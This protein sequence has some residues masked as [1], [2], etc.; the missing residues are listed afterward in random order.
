MEVS[1]EALHQQ[2][3]RRRWLQMLSLLP[4]LWADPEVARAIE[5]M[6]VSPEA[7]RHWRQMLSLLP[8]LWADPEVAI[9]ASRNVPLHQRAWQFCLHRHGLD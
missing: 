3:L 2:P 7:L 4:K 5:V 6:E 8:K 9:A 1:R